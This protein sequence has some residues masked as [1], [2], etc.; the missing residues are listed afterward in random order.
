[1][2]RKPKHT[3][4]HPPKTD[5]HQSVGTPVSYRRWGVAILMA[6]SVG[7]TGC[8]TFR[9]PANPFAGKLSKT[10]LPVPKLPSLSKLPTPNFSNIARAIKTPAQQVTS[11]RTSIASAKNQPPPPPSRKFDSA[12]T[13]EKFELATN[14]EK[15]FTP[16]F[17]TSNSV[18]QD[19]SGELTAAQKRFKEAVTSNQKAK[20][21]LNASNN[22][23]GGLWGDYQPDPA[24]SPSVNNIEDLA[25]VNRQ[26]YD[27]YGK[28]TTSNSSSKLSEPF[29][30]KSFAT[31]ATNAD[32]EKTNESVAELKAQLEKMKARGT[33]TSDEF[34]IPSRSAVELAGSAPLAPI[35]TEPELQVHKGFGKQIQLKA[36]NDL[37]NRG[38]VNIPDPT[39]PANVLRASAS[40]IPGLIQSTDIAGPGKY[41]ATQFGGY[42]SNKV[43][44][45]ELPTG[46]RLPESD[47]ELVANK[48][49]ETM[50]QQEIPT[51]TATPKAN[52][53]EMPLPREVSEASLSALAENARVAAEAAP[54]KVTFQ[55]PIVHTPVKMPQQVTPLAPATTPVAT[56]ANVAK[57]T[58]SSAFQIPATQTTQVTRN[59]FFQRPIES[60]A[61]LNVAA[62]PIERVAEAP[63]QEF[64]PMSIMQQPES[65]STALPAG[66]VTGDSTYAPGSVVRPQNESL[67]R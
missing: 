19:A 61:P 26:L 58:P 7:F 8:Q 51:L 57:A 27:Q 16:D 50:N 47:D 5:C 21:N 13:D 64:A 4:N 65:A 23:G 17:K 12:L 25:K 63:A 62:A 32:I 38:T 28:L 31:K 46:N 29:D 34:S 33:G 14:A 60:S 56:F 10:R 66:L 30:P 44:P 54:P 6:A 48:F 1:M 55:N 39:A 24:N 2:R 11:A 20:P 18:G 41:S 52:N 22:T 53:F 9:F 43:N 42:G 45:L 40:E 49:V 36:A 59:Q 15:K 3:E 67:W 37:A 35:E